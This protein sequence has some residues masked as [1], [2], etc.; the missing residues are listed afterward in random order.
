[1]RF[2][3]PWWLA[4]VPAAAWVLWLRSRPRRRQAV[5]YSS[6]L[7]LKQLPRTLAQRVRSSLPLL[8]ATGLGLLAIALAR[9]QSGRE[10]SVVSTYGV[11]IQLV[12]DKSQSMAEGDLD[13]DPWDRTQLTRLDVVKQVVADFVDPEGDLPGRESDLLGLTSFAGYAQAHC[14]LTLD[15]AAFL[16]LLETVEIPRV[17]ERDPAARE[18]LM[19]AIG[20]AL[21][22]AVDR[23]RD[24]PAKTKL[25]VL[26]SDGESNIG[27]ASPRAAAEAAREAGVRVYTIGVGTPRQ[28]L[29]ED[30]L[31]EVAGITGGHY[32]NARD[33]AGL[34][35]I[36]EEIDG[37]ERSEIISVQYTRWRERFLAFLLSGLGCLV[38]HRIL[39]DTRFRS[40]P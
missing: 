33:A 5:L 14:P 30:T 35:R 21:V 26:L 15:H 8:E 2:A 16:K 7:Q 31:R 28:G 22:I 4:L 39:M 20:D 19:T 34:E 37:L 17:D 10:D 40:L 11:A 3:D 25:V 38:A 36:Y 6:A 32:F 1:M 24:A 13:P 23:L 9:P 18:Q 29:D 12:L 27:E